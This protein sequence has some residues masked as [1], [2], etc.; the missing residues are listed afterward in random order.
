MVPLPEFS[1]EPSLLQAKQAQFPQP[2][3]IGEVLQPSDHLS[4]P[5]LD[6]LQQLCVFIVLG[7]PSLDTVLQMEPHKGRVEGNHHLFLPAGHLSFDAGQDAVG[8]LGLK[9]MLLAHV[10]LL[11]HQDPQVFLCRAALTEFF[12]QSVYTSG[13]ALTQIQDHALSLVEPH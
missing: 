13:I 5:P 6:P 7:A 3:L 10:Q 11:V 8:P 12:S 9:Y 2:F 1:Q 4:S